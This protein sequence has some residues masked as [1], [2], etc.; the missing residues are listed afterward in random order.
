[1]RI[2][3]E[4]TSEWQRLDGSQ[5]AEWDREPSVVCFHVSDLHGQLVPQHHVYYDNPDSRPDFDFGEDDRV[6]ERAGG[7]PLLTAKLECI[8]LPTSV[9]TLTSC[10]CLTL[11]ALERRQRA[12]RRTT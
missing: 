8:A 9:P 2:D 10:Q 6:L 1:M 11:T 7:V 3:T 5:S 12:R 4:Y